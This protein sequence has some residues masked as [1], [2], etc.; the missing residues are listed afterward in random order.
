MGGSYAAFG[1]RRARGLRMVLVSIFLWIVWRRLRRD[2]VSVK[3]AW[4][5]LTLLALLTYPRTPDVRPQL[6][7][8]VAFAALVSALC[9]NDRKP[10]TAHLLSIPILMANLGE[11]SR[12]LHRRIAPP[13]IVG[14]A[15]VIE[16]RVSL[17]TSLLAAG[18]VCLAVL[19]TLLNPYGLDS[20]AVSLAHVGLQRSDIVEWYAMPSAGYGVF[21]MSAI[22]LALAIA[23]IEYQQGPLRPH[24]VG[25][26]GDPG[27]CVLQ[28]QS[29]GCLLCDRHQ[30]CVLVRRSRRCGK[31]GPQRGPRRLA[32]RMAAAVLVLCLCSAG[33][34]LVRAA[35]R[36]NECI[37]TPAWLP[38]Q[39]AAGFVARNNL[40]GRMI[41]FYNWGT[42]SGTSLRNCGFPPTAGRKRSTRTVTSTIISSFTRER[43]RD[44]PMRRS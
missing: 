10:K 5:V 22:A 35:P 39:A 37:E 17:K 33:F 30:S 27:A 12:R 25:L 4:G 41:V 34:T 24:R 2:S 16:S 28:G 38:E 19:A 36:S 8:L 18:M 21:G 11:L 9:D 44:W 42:R 6:F 31:G 20:L 43:T 13:G 26:C 14:P 3:A 29:P 15:Y 32:P 40:Q 1:A 23:G 7:S